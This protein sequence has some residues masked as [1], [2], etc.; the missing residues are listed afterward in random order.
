M[1]SR[2]LA[3]LLVV[4]AALAFSFMASAKPKKGEK[5]AAAEGESAAPAA[6]V[7][8]DPAGVTGISPYQELIV[9][10]QNAYTSGDK[11]GAIAAFQEATQLDGDKMLGFYRLGEALRGSDKLGEAS[12]AYETALGKKGNAAL[13]AKVLFVL[14]DLRER[15]GKWQE[16]KDA[17]I[18]YATFL[19]ENPKAGGF[20]ATPA[21]RLKMIERRMKDEK[22]YGEVKARTEKRRAEVEKEAEDNKKKDTKNR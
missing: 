21:E 1:R 19:E 14:A 5:K 18:A 10:G 13:K 16:A 11:P 6:T 22:T 3:S 8:R 7:R 12:T 2:V 17:W 4:S 15:Q 9:K 20:P